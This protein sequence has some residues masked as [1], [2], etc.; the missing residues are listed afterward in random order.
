MR[1]KISWR[2]GEDGHL[3]SCDEELRYALA[4]AEQDAGRQP[5]IAA[6]TLDDGDSLSIGLGREVSVL[7][8]VGASG[9]PPYFSSQGR[10][11]RR[12]DEGVVFHYF[13]HWTGFPPSAAL[14]V[15]DAVEAVRYFCEH[16]ELSPQVDWVEV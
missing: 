14:P 10:A 7:S 13:G 5:L 16:G 1:A 2:E 4:E 15:E 8:F 3:V 6:V 12:D 11:R 9:M